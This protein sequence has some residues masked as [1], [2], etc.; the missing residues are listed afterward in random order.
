MK[1][2]K[3]KALPSHKLG[4]LDKLEH[5]KASVR[6]VEDPFYV[7]KNQW[8]HRKARYRSLVKNTA[9]LFTLCAFADLVLAGRSFTAN[10]TKKSVLSA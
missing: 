4:M 8:R 2:S 7:I 9:Q 6:E 3:C 10:E 1:R 5:L